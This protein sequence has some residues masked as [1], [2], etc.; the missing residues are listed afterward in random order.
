M[1]SLLAIAIVA[2][3]LLGQALLSPVTHASALPSLQQAQMLMLMTPV[4]PM[5]PL[6][7]HRCI[8]S[9]A[10]QDSTPDSRAPCI[11]GPRLS[12]AAPPLG[13]LLTTQQSSAPA[14]AALSLLSPHFSPET[15]PCRLCDVRPPGDACALSMIVL[16]Q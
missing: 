5:S 16:R 4:L 7:C 12:Q 14:M 13:A 9:V 6:H 1:K 11:P 8:V 3:A 15:P 2:Y 10:P